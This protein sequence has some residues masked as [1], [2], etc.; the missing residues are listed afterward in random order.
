MTSAAE[1]KIVWLDANKKRCTVDGIVYIK[2]R[3]KPKVKVDRKQYMIHYRKN[4]KNQLR[5]L[6]NQVRAMS[7]LHEYDSNS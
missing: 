7:N 3:A 5:V 4:K 6:Q 2:S 1:Q